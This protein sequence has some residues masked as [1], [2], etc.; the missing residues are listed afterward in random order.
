MSIN[1]RAEPAQGARAPPGSSTRG[2]SVADLTRQ[3]LQLRAGGSTH[4]AIAIALGLSIRRVQ[5][6]LTRGRYPSTN[7]GPFQAVD[8]DADY[9]AVNSAL[10][11][12]SN[13][14]AQHRIYA[15]AAP[16]PFS[17]SHFW[18]RLK[19]YQASETGQ[20]GV[21]QFAAIARKKLDFG[22][23]FV[24]PDKFRSLENGLLFL[25]E[26][27]IALQ[28]RKGAF[29]VRYHDGVERIFP[30]GRH[31]LRSV[32]LGGHGAS[33]TTEAMRFAID[34]GIAILVMHRA[35]EAF[36]L[37]TDAPTMNTST[38]ALDFRRAQFAATPRQ[39]LDIARAILRMKIENSELAEHET[40][41]ALSGI[42]HAQNHDDLLMI[43]ARAA[44]IYWKRWIG[45]RPRLT[46]RCPVAWTTFRGRLER[47]GSQAIQRWAKTPC[48][49]ALN[50]S[51]SIALGNC[52]R[53]AVGLGLDPAFGFLHHGD[54]P[55]RLSLSYDIIELVRPAVDRAVFRLL[56][57]RAFDRK[58][59]VEIPGGKAGGA[60]VRL[61]PKTARD[62]ALT[63]LKNV[64]FE[65]CEDA[66]RA[67]SRAILSGG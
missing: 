23:G 17:F 33:I 41:D 59:F 61:A 21:A 32:I 28:V 40:R 35:G 45:F 9:A 5:N 13:L 30:R 11:A 46:D 67:V 38:A 3:I 6:V 24:G 50:Y 43:E 29:C 34:E 1:D 52:T 63:V 42:T 25:A 65:L 31:H 44:S 20:S 62:V 53:A 8:R 18:R 64:P 51:Y 36:S 7:S 47:R 26:R 66:A 60:H 48:N 58:E 4:R 55:G 37:L 15:S 57:S 27:G 10:L 54:A 14:K 19:D 22:E 12:G 16:A 49:A 39:R 2:P 56:Q